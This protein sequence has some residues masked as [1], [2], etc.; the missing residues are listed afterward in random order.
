MRKVPGVSLNTGVLNNSCFNETVQQW[1]SNDQAFRF[2]N[3][4]KGTPLYWKKFK[5]EVLVCYGETVRCSNMFSH[6][7][8]CR[9][10]VEG[11]SSDNAKTK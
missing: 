8:M 4:V 10:S 7:I 11:I 2:M 6:V 5:S 9:S 1:V 3:S